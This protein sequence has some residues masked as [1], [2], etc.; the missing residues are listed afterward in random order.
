MGIFL[1]DSSPWNPK[2]FFQKKIVQDAKSK[3]IDTLE[4]TYKFYAMY[5]KI[6]G[7]VY[8]KQQT[9]KRT[10]LDKWILSRL[11]STIKLVT[12]YMDRY[13]F[14]QATRE[15]AALIDELS[16]WYVRRSRNRFFGLLDFQRINELPIQHFF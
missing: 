14:T 7:F 12:G 11:Y 3:L 10:L 13:Q 8:D 2:R 5:A 16:N 6:D 9:G 1:V 4:N 15:I